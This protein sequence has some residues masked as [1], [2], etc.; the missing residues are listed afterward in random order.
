MF[1]RKSFKISH[2]SLTFNNIPVAQVVSQK[3]LGISLN[4]KL[5]F[6]EH[7]RN[8]QSKVNRI[9]GIIRNLQNV[10]PRSALSRIDKSFARPHLECCDVI[11]DKA[12]NGAFKSKSESIQYN[13]A[14]AITGAIKGSSREKLYQELGLEFLSMRSWY[15]KLNLLFKI[16][17]TESPPYLFN[18]V[19]NNNGRQITRNLNNLPILRVNHEYFKNTFFSIS[20]IR[21]EQIRFFY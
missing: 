11:Y 3:H 13:A 8:I 10:L 2:S 5:N 14:L 21:M 9:I 20:S 17:K 15:R 12:Y 4:S 7:L 18:L 19:R 6:D 1:S 16:I